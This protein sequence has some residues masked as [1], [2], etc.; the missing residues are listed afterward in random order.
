MREA[1]EKLSKVVRRD[2]LSNMVRKTVQYRAFRPGPQSAL[3]P[4]LKM[5][6]LFLS[7][8]KCYRGKLSLKVT[9]FEKLLTLNVR[10]EFESYLRYQ[11]W[12][13]DV[14]N[15]GA[16]F[17]I[18]AKPGKIYFFRQGMTVLS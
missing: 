6:P 13:R 16:L 10:V 2:A 3:G 14:E 8:K 17:Q 9:V 18:G 5:F 11:S 4:V 12:Y 1:H 7:S 15:L